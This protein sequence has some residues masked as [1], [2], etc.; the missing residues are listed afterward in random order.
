MAITTPRPTRPD[1][2]PRFMRA[3]DVIRETGMGKTKVYDLL[4]SGELPSIQIGKVRLIAV[5]D[6]EHFIA[7][8]RGPAKPKGGHHDD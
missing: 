7:E 2:P 1:N 5:E 6:F 3:Y 4:A 8:R